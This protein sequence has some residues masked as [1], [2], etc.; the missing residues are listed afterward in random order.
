MWNCI[1][2][3]SDDDSFRAHDHCTVYKCTCWL[4]I[5]LLLLACTCTFRMD[6]GSATPWH[7]IAYIKI[8]YTLTYIYKID[9]S[10]ERHC[11]RVA[12]VQ[13]IAGY[14]ENIVRSCL[15]LCITFYTVYSLYVCAK[16]ATRV[17]ID[18]PAALADVSSDS[19]YAELEPIEKKKL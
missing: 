13:R 5:N 8:S 11:E 6:V 17:N 10:H 19:E 15:C 4:Q 7:V 12:N 18:L 1:L 3:I 9:I 16:H 14:G 2:Y